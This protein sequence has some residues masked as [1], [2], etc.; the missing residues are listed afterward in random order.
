M[1][2]IEFK[3]NGQVLT[4]VDNEKII[5]KSHNTYKCRFT[6]EE[7]SEWTNVNKFVI[8]TDGWGNSSTQHLGKNS[9]ILSCLI[10]SGMLQGSY[11][12]ISVYGG[13]LTT[14]NSLSIALVQSGYKR[15]IP[16][17]HNHHHCNDED[18]WVEIF[19]SLDTIIDSI[20]YDNHTLHLYHKDDLI[21]SIYLPFIEENELSNLVDELVNT[22]IPLATSEKE[23]LLSSEDKTKLDTIEPNANYIIVDNELDEEST[24]PISNQTVTRALQEKEDKYDVVERIDDIIIELIQKGQ[25][26]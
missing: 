20:I 15:T 14:T 4:R 9:N 19:N 5:G 1:N 22:K 21:E 18:I 12:K 24:N 10:P 7:D 2:T 13:H 11:F 25:N 16:F 8:F 3:V 17:H 23:G 26:I 6:F